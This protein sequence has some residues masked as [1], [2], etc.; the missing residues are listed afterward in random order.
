MKRLFDYADRYLQKSDWKDLTV[1]KFCLFS[2]GLLAGTYIPQKKKDCVRIIA[3]T[4]FVVTYVPLMAKLCKI[5]ADKNEWD[6]IKK[7]E[8]SV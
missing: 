5:I 4:V 6:R 7:K 8:D 2:M 3:F 1:I